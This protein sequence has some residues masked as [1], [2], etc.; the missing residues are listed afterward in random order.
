[1]P[2]M[3]IGT[4]PTLV[5][6]EDFAN[7]CDH[8]YDSHVANTHINGIH[9]ST[10]CIIDPINEFFFET[11][12]F[13]GQFDGRE[14]RHRKFEEAMAFHDACVIENGGKVAVQGPA[15]PSLRNRRVI[16]LRKT[17]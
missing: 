15:T 11:M 5:S 6:E 4:T 1:M 10:V 12:I 3:L 17:P 16:R 8:G 9:I 7:A 2:Y 14:R 13:G